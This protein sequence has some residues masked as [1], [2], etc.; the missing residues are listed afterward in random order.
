[1][2]YIIGFFNNCIKAPMSYTSIKYFALVFLAVIFYYIFPRKHRWLILLLVSGLFYYAI[3]GSRKQL[4]V[5]G[6]AVLACYGMG[7]LLA[8]KQESSIEVRCILLWAGIVISAGPL[9]LSKLGDFVSLTVLHRE[10]INWIIPIGLS[11]YSLQMVSYLV[12]IHKGKIKPEKN[13]LKFGLYIS[14][15]PIIIQGPISRFGQLGKALFMGHRYR[16]E[17]I[18]NGVQ[19][20]LWGLFLKLMIADK[21]AVIANRIFDGYQNYAGFFI[22]LAGILYTLQLYTDFL[23][24]VTISQGV[25]RLFGVKVRDNFARPLLATSIRDFWRRWHISLSEWL[26]DYIYFPLGG[27]RK[28]KARKCFN[29]LATFTVSGLWHGQGWKFLVWGWYHAV[30]QIIGDLTKK[31]KER[32]CA[33]VSMPEGS[34]IRK[35]V[36]VIV[37]FFLCMIGW[38][39]FRAGSLGAG[40]SMLRAM[41]THFN[42]WILFDGSLYRLGLSQ[43]EWGVLLVSI[44]FLILVELLQERGVKV[45]AW[46]NRQNL[47]I[48]WT[49]YFTVIWSIWIFGTYGFGFE[50]KDFIYGGF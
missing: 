11:F 20:I 44:L 49:I 27:S 6:L 22:L 23:S 30:C 47:L 24:C 37:T 19:G 31:P 25:A 8:K 17:N 32:L 33:A 42:P 50:A 41:V 4:L 3:S 29:L 45:R 43:K 9:I 46:I 35:V 26:R 15:F 39:F 1:M 18:I 38:I 48:R 13:P 10:E 28:G 7:L 36:Q 16:T 34:R 2:D 14:F 5:F 21:A 12:D 40:L